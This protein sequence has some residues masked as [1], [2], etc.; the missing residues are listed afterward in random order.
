MSELLKSAI[1]EIDYA[2]VT[3]KGGKEVKEHYLNNAK[4]LIAEEMEG[5]DKLDKYD[6]EKVVKVLEKVVANAPK[7]LLEETGSAVWYEIIPLEIAL[8]KLKMQLENLKEEA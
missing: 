3:N 1:S 4:R 7:S 6:I 2:L 8:R 5:E